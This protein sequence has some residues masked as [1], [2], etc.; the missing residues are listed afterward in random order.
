M[1]ACIFTEVLKNNTIYCLNNILEISQIILC[2]LGDVFIPII[3]VI[4]VAT[5][6]LWQFSAARISSSL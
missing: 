3:S 5:I 4:R 2:W 1:E 6:L